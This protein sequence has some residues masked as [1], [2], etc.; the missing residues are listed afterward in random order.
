VEHAAR[1]LGEGAGSVTEV[2]YAVGFNSLSYFNR[3]FRE[4]YGAAP[5][6]Y[7]RTA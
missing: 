6:E 7:L 3:A 4:R 1:L 2:A 5:S